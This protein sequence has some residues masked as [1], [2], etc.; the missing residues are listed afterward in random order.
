MRNDAQITVKCEIGF[1]TS[2]SF[3]EIKKE[4]PESHTNTNDHI[5]SKFGGSFFFFLFLHL[6]CWRM[7]RWTIG[8]CFSIAIKGN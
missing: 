8:V 6:T 1:E 2:L 7:T 4:R 5:V 3:P